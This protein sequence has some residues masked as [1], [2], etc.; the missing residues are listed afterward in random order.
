M[1][2]ELNSGQRGDNQEG[3]R[4]AGQSGSKRL[5][6]VLAGLLVILVLLGSVAV[7]QQEQISSLDR[8]LGTGTAVI[9]GVRYWDMPFPLSAPNG[10]S[11]KF[12]G[13]TFTSMSPSFQN[14]YSDPSK[15]I[16]Y[17]SVR[18]SNGTSLNLTGKAVEITTSGFTISME[19]R[20]TFSSAVVVSFPTGE[21]E[22]YNGYTITAVNFRATMNIP[23]EHVL[24]NVTYHPLAV[25]PWFT[26]HTNPQA[27]VLY[28]YV[29]DELTF[30]VS[31]G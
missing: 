28:S 11:V 12:H 20:G 5:K 17:G 9:G 6:A 21:S 27:G 15:Y 26:K 31:T 1:G 8:Q 2:T 29:S 18:L 16:F 30:Y 4:R 14:S 24:L 7:Y 3:L 13:V 23:Y 10:T 22:V 19:T 25:D